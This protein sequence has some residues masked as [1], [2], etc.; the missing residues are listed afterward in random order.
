MNLYI[1]SQ[2]LQTVGHAALLSGV[3]FLPTDDEVEV[4]P[5]VVEAPVQSTMRVSLSLQ[6]RLRK[7]TYRAGEA[8]DLDVF[9]V[10]NGTSSWYV[11]N[12]FI[13][14]GQIRL[15]VTS[16][17]GA[18]YHFNGW[19][20]KVEAGRPKEKG[21]FVRL[22]PEGIVGRSKALAGIVSIRAPGTYKLRVR[23]SDCGGGTVGKQLGLRAWSGELSSDPITIKVIG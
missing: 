10:N 1:L 17:E 13:Y 18:E 8:I 9:V 23:Y 11:W 19:N 6:G 5:S 22:E 15:T 2:G 4:S 7:S 3:M 16:S 21:D 12:S 20:Y 14:G